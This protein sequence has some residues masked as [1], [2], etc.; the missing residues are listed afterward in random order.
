[1]SRKFRHCSYGSD[2]DLDEV[3]LKMTYVVFDASYAASFLTVHYST[4]VFYLED[5]LQ[6]CIDN[7]QSHTNRVASPSQSLKRL[8]QYIPY[9]LVI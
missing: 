4:Y 8:T 5:V 2:S 6:K 3:I 1:M 7:L 9:K